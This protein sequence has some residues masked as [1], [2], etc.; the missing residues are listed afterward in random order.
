MKKTLILAAACC[1][2]FGACKKDDN[3]GGSK[4]ENLK[5]G[6][7]QLTK[8]TLTFPL[9]EQ[10]LLAN[11]DA[12]MK[13]NFYIFN[14]DQSITADA[15]ATKCNSSEPQQAT[16]GTWE[17]NTNDTRLKISGSSIT[18]GFGD[19][20]GDIVQLDA[21]TLKVKK[22]TTV[23]SLTGVINVTFTNKK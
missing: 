22:D 19:I 18:Q 8:L 16:D 11:L 3:N 23:G 6:K 12:C 1:M 17:L 7:W 15:G 4:S 21:S 9:G 2:A 20:Q 5:N 10:D 13:D 14:T